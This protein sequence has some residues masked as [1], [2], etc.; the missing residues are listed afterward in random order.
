MKLSTREAARLRECARHIR[1]RNLLRDLLQSEGVF[2][3][4]E[5]VADW[6]VERLREQSGEA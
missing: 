4:A 6:V 2:D 5:K 3:E 1:F